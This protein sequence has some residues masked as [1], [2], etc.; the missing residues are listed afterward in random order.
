MNFRDIIVTAI[1]NAPGNYNINTTHTAADGT[2]STTATTINVLAK[3]TIDPPVCIVGYPRTWTPPALPSGATLILDSEIE[4]SSGGTANSY[5][6]ATSTPLNQAL[7]VRSSTGQILGASEVKSASVRSSDQTGPLAVE[8]Y[9]TYQIVEMAVVVYGDI[10][11]AEIQCQ[12]IIG[13][14]T[15]TDGNTVR[16]LTATSFNSWNEHILI[17]NKPRVAHSNCHKFNVRQQF[18]NITQFN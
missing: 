5:T 7:V 13:G 1:E 18:L 6:I 11:N 12:I 16:N 3:V 9:L 10:G 15:Y 4:T 17:Y 2:T 8:N 14:V